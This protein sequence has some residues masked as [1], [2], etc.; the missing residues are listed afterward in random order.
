[1]PVKSYYFLNW[2]VIL[3][4]EYKFC[5]CVC[6]YIHIYFPWVLSGLN[7]CPLCIL[8]FQSWW[9]F[10]FWRMKIA[11]FNEIYLILVFMITVVC[12]LL[13]KSL[14][15]LR[16]WRWFLMLPSMCAQLLQLC[17]ALCDLSLWTLADLAPPSMGF[18]RQ[19]YWS[20]LPLPAPPMLPYRSFIFTFYI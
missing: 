4:S 2:F 5:L 16:M 18:S 1:M 17:P 12:D 6:M 19:E 7:H 9:P 11:N 3:Y 14:L 20:G 13:K 8:S 15:R 10:F